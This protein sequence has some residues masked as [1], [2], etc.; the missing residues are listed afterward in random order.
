MVDLVDLLRV[1]LQFGSTLAWSDC[2][3]LLVRGSEFRDPDYLPLRRVVDQ[4]RQDQA[5][6]RRDCST[7]FADLHLHQGSWFDRGEAAVQ[8]A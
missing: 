8:V 5:A 3:E 1:M 4:I 7:V 6:R 2:A